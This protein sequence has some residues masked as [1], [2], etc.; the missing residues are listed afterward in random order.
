MQLVL[1]ML[2]MHSRIIAWV[3]GFKWPQAGET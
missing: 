3:L 1:E 2:Q